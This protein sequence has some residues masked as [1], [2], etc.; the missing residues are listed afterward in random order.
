MFLAST[1]AFA[2]IYL[3]KASNTFHTTFCEMTHELRVPRYCLVDQRT[4]AGRSKL[5]IRSGWA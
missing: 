1:S 5:V 3:D 4:G 2:W